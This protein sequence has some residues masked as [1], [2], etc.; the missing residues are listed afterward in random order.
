M[1]SN[2]FK[3]IYKHYVNVDFTPQAKGNL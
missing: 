3:T 2:F 1:S